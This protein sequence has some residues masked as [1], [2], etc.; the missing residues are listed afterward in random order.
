MNHV[1]FRC[2]LLLLGTGIA[3]SQ[4]AAAR[5]TTIVHGGTIGDQTW[6]LA[7]SPYIIEGDVVVGAD[8]IL[9]IQEGVE[10]R[11]ADAD[12]Q[13]GGADPL[14]IEL[15]VLGGLIVDS[16]GVLEGSPTQPVLF[17][18]HDRR[19]PGTWA[20]ISLPPGDGVVQIY[21]AVISDADV[22]VSCA[23]PNAK[24]RWSSF[25]NNRTALALD[26]ACYVEG[27][28]VQRN[29]AGIDIELGAVAPRV[30]N[31]VVANNTTGIA[32]FGAE[33][34]SALWLTNVTIAGNEH[35]L[36][37]DNAYVQVVNSIIA[38]NPIEATDA[39]VLIRYSD[40]WSAAIDGSV[41]NVAT[42]NLFLD[43]Q[44]VSPFDDLR[45]SS[46][47][48]CIG[49]GNNSFIGGWDPDGVER[50]TGGSD[51]GAFEHVALDP[52]E[53][54]LAALAAEQVARVTCDASREVC[55]G[56]RATCDASLS[57]C[58]GSLATCDDSLA[59]CDD[60]LAS[61]DDLFDA[62]LDALAVERAA[63]AA[64]DTSLGS[65]NGLLAMCDVSLATC[66]VSLA[67]FRS[68][69]ATFRSRPAMVRS[70]PATVRSWPATV[71]AMRWLPRWPRWCLSPTAIAT[72]P[73]T[74]ATDAP[75]RRRE[76]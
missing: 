48:P 15:I 65:C 55:E 6:R 64:C 56:A 32:V 44:F 68:R 39:E 5:A 4:S 46:R 27:V 72:G 60:S 14:R 59:G 49:S 40:L 35:G 34:S 20:G 2:G 76:A 3:V 19:G 50:P 51:I 9:R 17:R 37:V 53:A 58:A 38:Q 66:D 18:G 63:L 30:M 11:F 23:R 42:G 29:G 62:T 75:A 7:D 45:L 28:I 24:V 52:L 54:A 70:R 73:A 12:S 31:S 69:P 1:I 21:G 13:F 25:D 16:S 47:S 57:T 10:V 71:S 33:A 36:L 8:A 43:P 67:T 26:D 41:V 22:A 74:R 61:C